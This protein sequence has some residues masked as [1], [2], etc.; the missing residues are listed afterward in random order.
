MIPQGVPQ[1]QCNTHTGV[2]GNNGYEYDNFMVNE[3]S[4][5]TRQTQLQ[6]EFQN[7]PQPEPAPLPEN[8][9]EIQELPQPEDEPHDLTP[10]YESN[11]VE[12]DNN[13]MYDDYNGVNVTDVLRDKNSG[14]EY[15]YVY[16]GVPKNSV[17]EFKNKLLRA[18]VQTKK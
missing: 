12:P 10:R 4:P 5:Q 6:S 13:D 7:E 3:I 2:C 15:Y 14:K 1:S 11:T 18:G 8:D 16:V 17:N 9:P